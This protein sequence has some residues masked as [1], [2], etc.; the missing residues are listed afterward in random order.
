MLQDSLAG[1]LVKTQF[2]SKRRGDQTIATL[3]ITCHGEAIENGMSEL[4][5]AD[6][7]KRFGAA[8]ADH[9]YATCSALSIE[10]QPLLIGP[11]VDVIV[12]AFVRSLAS[13][14]RRKRPRSVRRTRRMAS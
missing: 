9:G 12:A 14:G 11:D 10:T 13:G 7:T 5:K 3:T 6:V 1:V 8:C 2:A 4:F